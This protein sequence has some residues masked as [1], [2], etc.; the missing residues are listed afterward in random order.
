[1]GTKEEEEKNQTV[2]TKTATKMSG[3]SAWRRKEKL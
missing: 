1:M 3:A 2:K